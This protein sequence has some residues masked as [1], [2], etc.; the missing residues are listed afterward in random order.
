MV[1]GDNVTEILVTDE[2][3]FIGMIRTLYAALGKQRVSVTLPVWQTAFI[4]PA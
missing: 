3:D 2:V 1:K 4:L